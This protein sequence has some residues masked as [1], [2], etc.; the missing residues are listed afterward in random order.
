[1]AAGNLSATPTS[2]TFNVTTA[3]LTASAPL[4]LNNSGGA[5]ANYEVFAIPGAFTG[6][7]PVGPF[8]DHTRHFSPKDLNNKDASQIRVDLTPTAGIT[9]LAS[10]TV[11]TS[12]NTGLAYVWGI[13]L[14]TD[15]NDLWLGN[16][17]RGWVPGLAI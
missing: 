9:P 5:S 6:Y 8:A 12:W 4:T 1:M 16:P 11:S 13:G 7:A 14:N 2:M 17:P 10:G 15:A 3:A